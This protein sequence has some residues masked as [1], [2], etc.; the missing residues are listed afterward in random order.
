MDDQEDS[1]DHLETVLRPLVSSTGGSR[2]LLW[3]FLGNG[4][5][6]LRLAV[7]HELPAQGPTYFIDFQLSPERS[8]ALIQEYMVRFPDRSGL[9]AIVIDWKDFMPRL[10]L[11]PELTDL[12]KLSRVRWSLIAQCWSQNSFRGFL[13]VQHPGGGREWSAKD[14]EDLAQASREVCKILFKDEH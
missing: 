7:T 2:A 3:Q 13:E 6:S 5:K 9:G 12:L 4:Y 10:A 11:F 8:I 14:S 1:S